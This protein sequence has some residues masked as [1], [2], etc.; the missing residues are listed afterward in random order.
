MRLLVVLTFASACVPARSE[1]W[2]PVDRE[3]QRRL[4]ASPVWIDDERTD[5]AVHEL[6]GKPL[7]LDGA[8]RIALATNRHLQASYAELGVAAGGI[9]SATVLPPTEVD[10]D[11]KVA[12]DGPGDEI[13]V[14]AIQDVLGL[15]QLGQRR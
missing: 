12:L 6:L 7:E 14:S 5:A 8:I 10:L 4:G 11:Y 15:I 9:A 2:G 3:V 13:E 1:V